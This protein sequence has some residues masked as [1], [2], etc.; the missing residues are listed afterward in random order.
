[1][2][3]DIMWLK[4]WVRRFYTAN[5]YFMIAVYLS[6]SVVALAFFMGLPI[7]NMV[8]GILAGIYVGRK[9][10]HAGGGGNTFSRAVRKVSLL[11]AFVTTAEALPIGVLA[12]DEQSVVEF[13]RSFLALARSA[14]AWSS[15]V[16]LVAAMC[17]VLFAVQYWCT[18]ISA[19]FAFS[20]GRKDARAPAAQ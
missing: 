1:M 3:L 7:G 16:T 6:L 17:V 12:L 18:R 13:L 14:I 10:C 20:P 2:F 8:L 11:A 15:G 4:H 5:T 9:E 19:T